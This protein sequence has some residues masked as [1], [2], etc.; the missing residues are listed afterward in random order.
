MSIE[1]AQ[2]ATGK[3]LYRTKLARIGIAAGPGAAEAAKA[4]SLL[5]EAAV[6]LAAGKRA[7]D[8]ERYGSPEPAVGDAVVYVTA[9]GSGDDLPAKVT[10]LVKSEDGAVFYDLDV[11]DESAETPHRR[12]FAVRCKEGEGPNTFRRIPRTG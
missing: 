6:S 8:T 4:A 11:R 12:D 5:E 2:E 1:E 7:R 10:G 9:D 3:A